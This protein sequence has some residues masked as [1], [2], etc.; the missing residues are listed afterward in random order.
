[1]QGGQ[2][3][4][5]GT[6]TQ[7]LTAT[8]VNGKPAL[9][10]VETINAPM[11][12]G[13]AVDSSVVLRDGFAPVSHRS[14]NAQRTLSLDFSGNRVTGSITPKGGTAQ[15]I[16]FT[17]DAPLFDANVVGLLLRAAPLA[18]GYAVTIPAYIHEAGGKTSI[19]ARVTGSE[20]VDVGGKKVDAWVV[21]MNPGGRQVKQWVTKDTREVVRV[22][23]TAAPGVEIRAVK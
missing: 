6:V 14:V 22:V 20:Q 18:E 21:E 4:Q 5:L 9:R 17:G 11:M 16:N 7:E 10:S 23:I 12:G 15:A 8:T 19:T 2:E 13:T 1:V 3:Q